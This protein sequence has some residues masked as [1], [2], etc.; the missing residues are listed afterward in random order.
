MQ[1]LVK[2]G[3]S[4]AE[5]LRI[6][7][8]QNGGRL[9]SWIFI[10]LQYLSKIQICAYFFIDVQNLVKIGRSRAELLRFFRFSNGGRPPYWIW[11]DVIA[12]THDLYFHRPNIV[13]KLHVD[14]DYTL[15]DIAIFTFG[16]F[17]LKLPIHALFGSFFGGLLPPNEFRYCRNPQRTVLG[18]K[19]VV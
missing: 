13:L 1:N 12:D 9:P 18:R 14:R 19:H 6:F 5:L 11:Y 3:Q 2:I 15:Q 16:P 17:G 10:F 4:V 7:D 8:F